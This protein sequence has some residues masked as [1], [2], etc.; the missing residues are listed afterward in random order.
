MAGSRLLASHLIVVAGCLGLVAASLLYRAELGVNVALSCLA[1]VG[2]VSLLSRHS[3]IK[4][5]RPALAFLWTAAAFGLLFAFRDAPGLQVANGFALLVALGMALWV[6]RRDS[7]PDSGFFRV[8]A[9]PFGALLRTL[10]HFATL[11]NRLRAERPSKAKGGGNAG[12][13]LLGVVISSPLLLV[14]GGLFYTADALFKHR[15]DQVMSADLD[16]NNWVG[17]VNLAVV[18]TIFAGGA[19]YRLLDEPND[20]VSDRSPEFVGPPRQGRPARKPDPRQ[21]GHVE[22]TTVLTLLITLFAMF[23]AVQFESFF[24]GARVISASTGLTAAEYARSGFFQLAWVA[25]LALV[26]IISLEMVQ[27]EP[28]AATTWL[29]RGLIALVFLVIA[30]AAMR[31][32]VYADSFGLT[33]LRIYTSAFIVWVAASF[34]WLIPTV[35]AGRASKFG[36]GSIVA[37]FGI[38]VALNAA[39]PEAMIVRAN[40]DMA[41]PDLAYLG[42]LSDDAVA[43]WKSNPHVTPVQRAVLDKRHQESVGTQ[44][45]W[46]DWRSA[47]LARIFAGAD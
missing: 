32:K 39:N 42:S 40:L 8:V 18:L 46:S 16:M 15:V 22:H 11:L 4:P 34:A 14:F 21:L 25:G 5:S 20:A 9:T 17:F 27:T 33:E 6:A 19:L 7:M 37:G 30:S 2:A 12:K 43:E 36:L 45:N 24:G 44:D 10:A 3:P 31:M 35:T 13:M 41:N 47:N 29:T 38:I 28:T 26:T 23:I 1:A